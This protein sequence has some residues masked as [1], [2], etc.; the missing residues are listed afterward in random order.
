MERQRIPAGSHTTMLAESA[1]ADNAEAVGG[2]T[3]RRAK[4]EEGKRVLNVMKVNLV[5]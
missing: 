2:G 1:V 5:S 3:Y 4:L